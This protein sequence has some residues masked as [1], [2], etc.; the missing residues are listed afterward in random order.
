MTQDERL[1]ALDK[2]IRDTGK[3]TLE[4]ICDQFGVS[5]DSARRDLVKLTQLPGIQR[6]RGGAILEPEKSNALSYVERSQPNPVKISLAKHAAN[7]TL[8]HDVVILD[9]STLLTELAKQL[10]HPLSVITNSVDAF[11]HLSQNQNI[12]LCLLGGTFDN[13]TRAIVGSVAVE[14]V[15]SYLID[16]AFIGVC[17]LAD[18]GL[19]TDSEAESR[20]KKSMIQQAK[21]V[22]LVCEQS[23]FN[24]TCLYKVCDWD[25]ID[26][27]VTDTYP[28]DN[29][30]DKIEQHD[31]NLIITNHED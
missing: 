18:G 14:Q 8:P 26:C 19:S 27:I 16:K 10:I 24:K 1:I 12:R 9:T 5:Y 7:L 21:Y 15:K 22:V 11:Y 29:I 25:D 30:K 4:Y 6:I 28:P 2:I 17:A 23:K 13:F 20:I 3:V 31:I